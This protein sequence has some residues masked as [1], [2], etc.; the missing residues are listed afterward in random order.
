[1]V[2]LHEVL[3]DELPVGRHVV[4]HPVAHLQ[5]V[6]AVPVDRGGVAEPAGDVAD[7]VVGERRRR[8][9]QAHP[10]VAEPLGQRDR[11]QAVPVAVDAR[12]ALV[13]QRGDVGRGHEFAVQRVGPG[14][15]GTA[16]VAANLPF[17]LGAQLG[18]AVPADVEERAQHAV[19]SADHQDTLAAD[20]NLAE[21]S[22]VARSAERA[23]Q[24]HMFSKIALL[25][26]EDASLV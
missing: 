11:H 8:V 25:G 24:N 12:S 10:G 19:A 23:A 21:L 22:G 4:D 9:R 7:D 6:D 2:A 1:M 18:A 17:R 14:V 13:G 5:A 3:D 16:E 26:G 20:L 15:I